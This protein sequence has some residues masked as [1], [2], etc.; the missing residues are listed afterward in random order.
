MAMAMGFS[1]DL[2][3]SHNRH[4]KGISRSRQ[5]TSFFG[6]DVSELRQSSRGISNESF[7]VSANLH[8]VA[9]ETCPAAKATSLSI[10]RRLDAIDSQGL[11]VSKSGESLLDTGHVNVSSLGW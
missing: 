5:L 9:E 7:D 2:E 4:D 10:F 11:E 8:E 3:G 6:I 1:L